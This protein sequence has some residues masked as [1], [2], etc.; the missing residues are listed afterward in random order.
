MQRG[1]PSGT[2]TPLLLSAWE[3]QGGSFGAL[4]LAVSA[5]VASS[6]SPL[7]TRWGRA[8]LHGCTLLVV[9]GVNCWSAGWSDGS[10]PLL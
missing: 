5:V 4:S 10:V 1:L 8:A 7:Q 9:G 2:L 3:G 6:Q